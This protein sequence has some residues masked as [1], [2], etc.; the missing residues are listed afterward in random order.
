M[1]LKI[2]KENKCKRCKKER[3]KTNLFC[4][5]HY[6]YNILG[7]YKIEDKKQLTIKLIE[8]IKKQEFQCYYTGVIIYPGINASIDHKIPI[9]KNGTNSINNLVWCESSI[10]RMKGNKTDKE[11]ISLCTNQL[12][13]FNYLYSIENKKSLNYILNNL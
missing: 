10:N 7:Y 2:K 13:E 9:S 11:F 1:H 3:L 8:K 4:L 5:F 12:V 6:I